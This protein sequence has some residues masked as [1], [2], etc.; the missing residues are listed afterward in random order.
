MLEADSTDV[1]WVIDRD[2]AH[3][4]AREVVMGGGGGG[5]GGSGGVAVT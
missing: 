5:S 1:G 2:G 3:G 4:L